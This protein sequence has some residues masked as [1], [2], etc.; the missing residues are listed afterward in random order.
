[1][2]QSRNPRTL[3]TKHRS[4]AARRMSQTHPNPNRTDHMLTQIYARRH[5]AEY[6]MRTRFQSRVDLTPIPSTIEALRALPIPGPIE[7]GASRLS[8]EMHTYT[9]TARLLW[10]KLETD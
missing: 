2:M 5:A 1:M 10:D 6:P 3:T 8:P 7:F 4:A 9:L